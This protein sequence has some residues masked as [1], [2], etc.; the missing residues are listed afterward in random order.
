MCA[1]VYNWRLWKIHKLLGKKKLIRP[2]GRFVLKAQTRVFV[3]RLYLYFNRENIHNGPLIS[4]RKVRD[5]LQ[6][7]PQTVSR[8]LKETRIGEAY[9]RARLNPKSPSLDNLN[10]CALRNLIY[11]FYEL[12][13]WPTRAS[14]LRSFKNANLFHG[15]KSALSRILH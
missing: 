10:E 4:L 11:S 13:E 1:G 9:K 12:K 15:E 7:S 3:Y 8:I 6:I 5:A 2:S 14:L